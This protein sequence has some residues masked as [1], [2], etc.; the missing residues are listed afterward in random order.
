MGASN[1]MSARK[2]LSSKRKAHPKSDVHEKR[3][4]PDIQHTAGDT[5]DIR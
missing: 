1:D 3:Y 4:K 2:L 5:Y